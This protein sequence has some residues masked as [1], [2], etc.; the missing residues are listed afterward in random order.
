MHRLSLS[1]LALPAVPETIG[2]A[3]QYNTASPGTGG[4]SK[5]S[6]TENWG[7]PQS[8]R[9][10]GGRTGACISS[11]RNHKQGYV[12]EAP[13][14]DEWLR[15]FYVNDDGEIYLPCGMFGN[16]TGALL[17][18]VHDGV[19]YVSEDGHVYAPTKWLIKE[20]PKEAQNIAAMVGH[21]KRRLAEM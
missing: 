17:G 7:M 2:A 10:G 8:G 19:P 20:Y 5:N 15:A 13:V 1:T 4:R 11:R 3:W 6:S 21:I 18:L 12:L 14:F 9:L 16:E